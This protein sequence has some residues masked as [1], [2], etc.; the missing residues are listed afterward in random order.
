MTER[1]PHR[2]VL[3]NR[4]SAPEDSYPSRVVE[5]PG[6]AGK[7]LQVTLLVGVR[8]RHRA[9]GRLGHRLRNLAECAVQ[10]ARGH[11]EGLHAARVVLQPGA[12]TTDERGGPAGQRCDHA[13]APAEDNLDL[14]PQL[15]EEA[16]C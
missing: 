7:P 15:A 1:P 13:G 8:L 5:N 12:R 10:P 4:A 2:L 16:W 6:A 9:S 14:E 11:L 3:P